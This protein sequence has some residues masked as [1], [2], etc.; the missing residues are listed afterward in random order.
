MA[1]VRLLD[2]TAYLSLPSPEKPWLVEGLIPQ[3]SFVVLWGP[4]KAGK[5][6]LALQVGLMLAQG[7]R[8]WLHRTGSVGASSPVLFLELD[9]GT[10]LLRT[11]LDN[12]RQAGVDVS[13][14]L[15]F[16]HPEDLRTHYPVNLLHD[17]SHLYVHSLI[18]L[19]KPSL[20]IVDCL[21]ELGDHDEN[22]S[23]ETKR[24][25]SALK[26]LTI[27]HPTNPCACLLLHHTKK[28][29]TH[30]DRGYVI[31]HDPIDVGRGSSYLAGAVDSVWFL[32]NN[33]LKIVPRFSEPTQFKLKQGPGGWWGPA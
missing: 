16:P 15:Y 33:L 6:L 24:I 25:V 19:C 26:H 1:P 12:V 22:E 18:A 2:I 27:F 14:P 10:P 23:G 9:T 13:G 21:R 30:D 20:V 8:N 4:P 32:H 11:M 29:R 31:E 28:L 17:Q 3:E 5:T 7:T